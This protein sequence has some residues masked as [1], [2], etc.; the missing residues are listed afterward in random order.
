[1]LTVFAGV[2]S[3][4]AW[5]AMRFAEAVSEMASATVDTSRRFTY[6]IGDQ[7]EEFASGMSATLACAL[8]AVVWAPALACVMVIALVVGSPFTAILEVKNA[9]M[10]RANGATYAILVWARKKV[11]K[12]R[13][14]TDGE[15]LPSSPNPW[16][17][18][19]APSPS[20]DAKSAQD[21]G[22]PGG[23]ARGEPGTG[24]TQSRTPRQYQQRRT[25]I[26]RG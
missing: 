19:A 4:A 14:T 11:D 9:T 21:D 7:W 24:C 20:A 26:W 17:R 16:W 1:M 18:R 12:L 23:S 8:R 15:S 5:A 2:G 13:V 3:W 6:N 25:G 10:N 22:R